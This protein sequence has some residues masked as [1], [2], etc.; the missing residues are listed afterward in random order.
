MHFY[1]T[2]NGSLIFSPKKHP[3]W[4]YLNYSK[5]KVQFEI[6]TITKKLPRTETIIKRGDLFIIGYILTL[7][8]TRIITTRN[9]IMVAT[10]MPLMIQMCSESS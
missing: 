9:R 4:A 3:A 7:L 1:L 8:A 2:A 10:C 6:L 5:N